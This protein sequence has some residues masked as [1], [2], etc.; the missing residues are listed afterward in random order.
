VQLPRRYSFDDFFLVDNTFSR[1]FSMNG[2]YNEFIGNGIHY[3]VGE[4]YELARKLSRQ[5]MWR[6]LN[7][8]K[9][10]VSHFPQAPE[11]YNKV[12]DLIIRFYQRVRESVIN[13]EEIWVFLMEIVYK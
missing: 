10:R 12:F 1:N 13:L 3:L 11:A 7:A 8:N 5:K 6:E 2:P 4:Q 9:Y